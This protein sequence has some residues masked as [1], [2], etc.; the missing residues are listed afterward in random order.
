[1]KQFKTLSLI[2]F[3]FILSGCATGQPGSDQPKIISTPAPLNEE[4]TYNDYLK[5]LTS[6]NTNINYFGLRMAYTKTDKYYP[7]GFTIT[8]K[9][10]DE[11]QTLFNGGNTD[12]ALRKVAE[13][14]DGDYT[15]LMAHFNTSIYYDKLGDSGKSAFHKKIFQELIGSILSSGT[16]GT[17][18]EAMT[19][20]TVREEY[21]VL[22]Y[23]GYQVM[24]Q[25]LIEH[26][27]SSIDKLSAVDKNGVKKDFYF[28]VDLPLNKLDEILGEE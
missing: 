26:N 13:I 11:A 6:G 22:S 19:V 2:L 27:G 8:D 5:E 25:A 21:I 7:Y 10:Q 4:L 23:L 18:N 1:M 24:N 28:N 16:G 12:G 15:D 20:I 14:L 17:A 3:L 9:I